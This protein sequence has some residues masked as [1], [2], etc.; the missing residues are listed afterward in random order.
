MANKII[1]IN[2]SVSKD[3]AVPLIESLKA[4]GLESL[5]V[6][7][8]R[9]VLL[10][11]KKG[12]A[13][14]LGG[15][16]LLDDPVQTLSFL[17]PESNEMQMIDFIADKAMLHL[18]G[19]GS[20]YSR[21]VELL[22]CH[23]LCKEKELA[24]TATTRRVHQQDISCICCIVQKGF[25]NDV[26]KVGLDTATSIPT[27]IY[28]EGTGLRDK[29]GLWRI[30][31][32]AEKELITLKVS[33]DE[34]ADVMDM[35]IDRGQLDKPGMGFIFTYP[36]G[37]G[38]LNTKFS[39]TS[40][41]QVASIEQVV[42]AIDDIKGSTDWRKREFVTG[43]TGS[44]SRRYLTGL[45][46]LTLVCDEGRSGDLTAAA[47]ASGAAGATI[48]KIKNITFDETALKTLSP[49]REVSEMIVAEAQVKPILEALRQSGA[50]DEE[51]HGLLYSSPVP[52]A[53]T[54]L[55]P[56]KS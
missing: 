31:I 39:V 43:G 25:G 17:V 13:R 52:K 4:A 8:G 6:S 36:L 1:Q 49:A 24:P 50:F 55:G 16:S 19:R 48:S 42:A 53:C 18:P 35:M 27:I 10:Q 45:V 41:Q 14:L 5:T 44:R 54:Y 46:N 2:A 22:E 33:N 29:L 32:P 21:S 38:I 15:K 56:I 40:G 11:E 3:I 28:G 26:G 34:A 37:R 12:L 7:A 47:M 23:P 51:T 9:R 30:T 20:V